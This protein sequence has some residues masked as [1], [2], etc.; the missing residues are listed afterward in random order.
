[1]AESTVTFGDKEV[2]VDGAQKMKF[3]YQNVLQCKILYVLRRDE[4][5]DPTYK[6]KVEA[7]F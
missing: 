1:M 5:P 4:L 6:N 2:N 7:E 3:P